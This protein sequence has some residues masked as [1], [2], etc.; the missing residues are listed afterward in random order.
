M[1]QLL[2]FVY[3]VFACTLA[4]GQSIKGRL[5]DK[6]GDPIEF[7]SVASI[8]LADSTH[9]YSFAVSQENGRFELDNSNCAVDSVILKVRFMGFET[10]RIV[11]PKNYSF[12]MPIVLKPTDLML[13]EVVVSSYKKAFSLVDGKIGVDV[14]RL[15]NNAADN[16]LDVLKRMP[17]VQ[18]SKDGITMQGNNPLVVIDGVKQR[19]PIETLVNYLRS[20]P[21]SNVE[22]I[23]LQTNALAENRLSQGGATIEIITKKK[24]LDGYSIGSTTHGTQHRNQ[25]YRVGTYL[26]MLGK[27]GNLSGNASLGYSRPSYI[28]NK[29]EAYSSNSNQ[30]EREIKRKDCDLKNSYFGVLNLTWAPKV[31]NGSVNYFLSY[32][33]DDVKDKSEEEYWL[34]KTL[35]RTADRKETDWMDLLSTNIEYI[36]ADTLKNQFKA[37]YGFL[38]GLS[39]YEQSYSNSLGGVHSTTKNMEG[40]RHIIEAEYKLKLPKLEFK[41]GTESFFSQ[42]KES[43]VQNTVN[44]DF[45]VNE[46]IVG[47]YTS[48]NLRITPD[49]SLYLGVRG[50]YSL[51]N[52]QF[53]ENLKT[54]EWSMAPFVLINWKATKNYST[55][56]NFTMR[57]DRPGYFSLLPGQT[58]N[59]DEE[60][61]VGNPLLKPSMRY[62][63]KSQ[64][65]FFKYFVVT[66]GATFDEN[67]YGSTYNIDEHGIRYIMPRN[68]A[69][70]LY[71]FGSM[72]L[73]FSFFDGKLRGTLYLYGQN[74]RYSN[75][76]SELDNSIIN[77]QKTW[78]SSG[79]IYISYQPNDRL[80]VYINPYYRTVTKL[81]QKTIKGYSTMDFGVQYSFLKKKNLV[82]AVS[83]EDIF[84]QRGSEVIYNYGGNLVKSIELPNTQSIRLAITY[85]FSQ[86]TKTI[87]VNRNENDTSRFN[88]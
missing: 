16:V 83:V 12:A 41:V 7:A 86:N 4:Y 76:I 73:P 61:S 17:G 24:R 69:D 22:K 35:E 14:G 71:F 8:S 59:S 23:Y 79:D 21:A 10:M 46:T 38:T 80:G 33:I 18:V 82:M 30:R 52:Y 66:F 37:S 39:D 72:S 28:S 70:R 6:K 58:Y 81:L 34:V 44:S 31:L 13:D 45:V 15:S 62:S 5:T 26:D 43:T 50:E 84:N 60:Y 25:A 36:S 20:M 32:Y 75:I 77:P 54:E 63:L 40:Y 65:L 47:A 64:H 67:L 55:T 11:V 53:R 87:H 9:I 19:L 42:M 57:N 48:G 2:L 1:R 68:Y 56:F 49:L 74:G 3:I 85:T 27:Y 78:R 88:R 29:I 51:Y